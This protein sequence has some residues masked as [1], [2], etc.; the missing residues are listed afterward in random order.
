MG[1]IMKFEYFRHNPISLLIGDTIRYIKTRIKYPTLKIAVTAKV[2]NSVIGE[3][4][5]LGNRVEI[6]SSK[7]NSY[8]YFA[9]DD[10]FG[11]VTVGKFCSIGPNVRAGMGIHPTKTFVSTHPVFFSIKRQAQ[12]TFADKNYFKEVAKIEI[13]NDVWIGANVVILD[14]VKIG[15]GVIIGAGA[16]VTKDL[17]DYAIAVGVPAKVIKYR[18]EKEKIDF[19][20]K[21]K[22]WDKD[23]SWL[24][25]NYKYFHNINEYIKY[26]KVE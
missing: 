26:L 6:Y 13:G 21:D 7:V 12:I 18:F 23:I 10:K 20:L 11:N 25:K 8:T 17:P 1:Y 3:F 15:N 4:V 16:V 24:A 14:G 22:W 5:T 19:L 9:S 2:D